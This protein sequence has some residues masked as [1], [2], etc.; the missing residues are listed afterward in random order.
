M[1]TACHANGSIDIELRPE[2]AI[3]RLFI[4]EMLEAAVKGRT[5]TLSESV[6]GGMVVTVPK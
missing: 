1:Q 4:A 2:T 6:E 5:V 3:E